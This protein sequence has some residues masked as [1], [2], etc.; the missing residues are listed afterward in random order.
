M[1]RMSVD[2][3]LHDAKSSRQADAAARD[4]YNL[5]G[6]ELMQRAARA[7]LD[8]LLDRFP[9]ARCIAVLCG[10]GHNGGDGYLVAAF[11][12]EQGLEVRLVGLTDELTGDAVEAR[13]YAE[14]AG[15]QVQPLQALDWSGVEVVVDALLGTG[16]EGDLRPA[17]AEAVHA[18]N[19]ASKPVLA[20][21]IPSGINATS[22]GG[23]Q[24]VQADVT[25][26][27]IT[28]KA[29][30][31]TGP[32]RRCAGEVV[33]ADL[34]VTAGVEGVARSLR[35]QGLPAFTSNVYKH[36]LGHVLVVGG[37]QGMG[38]AVLLAGEAALRSGA[39]M[40]TVACQ[41][42]HHA[43]ILARRPEMMV[44]AVDSAVLHERLQAADLIVLGPGLG[45]S[46]WSEAVFR[47]LAMSTAPMVLD[48]DAL[49][50]LAQTQVELASSH[51]FITPHAGEA[52][53]LL[54]CET[55][56]IEDDRYTAARELRSRYNLKGALVKGPGTVISVTGDE[57]ENTY[58]CAHGNAGMATAGMGDVLAGV[59]G[60]LVAQ[61]VR[62]QLAAAPQRFCQAAALHSYAADIAVE[63]VGERSLLASDVI[64]ALPEALGIAPVI[65][66]VDQGGLG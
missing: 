36:A 44:T 18:V 8:V 2:T 65:V 3:W 26:T 62:S 55:Q 57:G 48:A 60:G 12:H 52:A 63:V 41:P 11:A 33:F 15:L 9:A 13:S 42:E 61:I 43:A 27:F 30:L 24:A 34:G 51:C 21:D 6:F 28:H 23:Q 58:V 49:Y 14:A 53:R 35:W 16:T 22:A 37:D 40:V 4:R 17:Y 31:A 7:A 39:G 50:W 64:D 59:A 45:R 29:G 32:G 54:E 10:K 25:V 47:D 19:T 20:I 56:S 1:P 38:G 66:P 46:D 5:A